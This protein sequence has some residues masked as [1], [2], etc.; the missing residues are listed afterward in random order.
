M[1]T[2]R[3][4]IIFILA[5]LH[6]GCGA[7]DANSGSTGMD[8]GVPFGDASVSATD[9]TLTDAGPSLDTAMVMDAATPAQD[10]QVPTVD[11]ATP[12]QDAQVPTVDAATPAQDAEIPTVDAAT[13]T[14]DADLTAVDAEVWPEADAS[15]PDPSAMIP[16]E[17]LLV[18]S[19][20]PEPDYIFTACPAEISVGA[21]RSAMQDILRRSPA[22]ELCP[23]QTGAA[24]GNGWCP[25]RGFAQSCWGYV[26]TGGDDN[27]TCDT[28]AIEFALAYMRN[29]QTDEERRACAVVT[30]VMSHEG[31]F[32]PTAKSWDMFCD[33]GNT[34]AIGLFQ[35]DFA[36]GLDPLP[37]GVDAQ[38]NQFFRGPSG[39]RFSGLADAWMAC[40]P[41]I[42]G[43]TAATM[44][45]YNDV[46]L[47]ACAQAGAPVDQMGPT[48]LNCRFQ[49][50]VPNPDDG[51]S[52]RCGT[53]WADA[54]GRCGARC[55][56][57]ED[58]ENGASC[59]VDLDTDICD[60]NTPTDSSTRCGTDW[61]D[62]SGRCGT[63]C[64][65]NADCDPDEACFADLDT[66]NCV[67]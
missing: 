18:P 12:A 25:V 27:T 8:A 7:E 10:A 19:S 64:T 37:A 48:D 13:S 33:G 43:A 50:D 65:T 38:F 67:R 56:T 60:E 45:D 5:L 36:S 9:A 51:Q 57:N 39:P 34:G 54:N 31:G 16:C 20:D 63:R 55:T 47:P 41:R 66:Q 3:T 29:A 21:C 58:C 52:T 30:A 32:A 40:N 2:T 59:F 46:A 17:D 24:A 1:N 61:T 15:T 14:Q 35:Y 62:A 44:S 42:A 53:N 6:W 4:Q 26:G 23:Y 28:G 22:A 11:A 49:G